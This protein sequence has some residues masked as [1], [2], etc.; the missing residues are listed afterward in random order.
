MRPLSR[1][2]KS[3]EDLKALHGSGATVPRTN[4]RLPVSQQLSPAPARDAA[5]AATEML[6]PEGPVDAQQIPAIVANI[7]LQVDAKIAEESARITGMMRE[8]VVR[9]INANLE[10]QIGDQIR[11][12]GTGVKAAV[13]EEMKKVIDAQAMAQGIEEKINSIEAS[14]GDRLREDFFDRLKESMDAEISQLNDNIS[15]NIATFRAEV[16]RHIETQLSGSLV[17][18]QRIDDTREY[19][20]DI[21]Q[22]ERRYREICASPS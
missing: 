5:M 3:F 13:E 22:N 11:E 15:T 4:L 2:F 1:P 6:I 16:D 9:D 12:M 8:D 10:N 14:L 17:T 20:D 18:N 21:G 19:V 7:L